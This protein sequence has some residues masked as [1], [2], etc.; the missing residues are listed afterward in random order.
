MAGIGSNAGTLPLGD[1]NAG[2]QM[3]TVARAENPE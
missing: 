1:A 2:E 3:I